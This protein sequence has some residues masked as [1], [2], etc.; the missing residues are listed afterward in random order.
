MGMRVN[1]HN[2][3]C[4]C[5]R[6]RLANELRFFYGSHGLLD[7]ILFVAN[8]GDIFSREITDLVVCDFPKLVGYLG[9]ETEVM[10][11]NHHTALK[12]LYSTS[13]GVN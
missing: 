12:V 9:D 2:R 3:S 10:R 1:F 4:F 8:N 11:N 7:K 6:C 5:F 13:E